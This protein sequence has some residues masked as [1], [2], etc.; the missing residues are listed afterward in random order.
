MI[1]ERIPLPHKTATG[2]TIPLGPLAIVMIVTDTGMIGCGAFD[3][4]AL[5]RFE[6]PAGRAR[7]SRGTTINDL[8]DLL[9]GNIKEVNRTAAR[10]GIREGMPVRE[11]LTLL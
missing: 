5:D 7:P 2:Y 9:E 10:H 3:V 4:L 6:Y 1:Q 8:N 11:A